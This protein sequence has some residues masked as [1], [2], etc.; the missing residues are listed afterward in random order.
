MDGEERV[1][2]QG[3]RVRLAVLIPEELMAQGQL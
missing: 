3:L 1:I 2:K